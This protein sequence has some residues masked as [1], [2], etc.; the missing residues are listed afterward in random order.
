MDISKKC[1]MA[2][3]ISQDTF[4]GVVLENVTEFDMSLEEAVADAIREFE[5]QGVLLGM[6]VKD[7][8][9]SDDRRSVIHSVVTSIE[10]LKSVAA[11]GT[12]TLEEVQEHLATL[13][14]QCSLSLSHRILANKNNAYD[15][16]IKLLQ[17]CKDNGAILNAC[18]KTLVAL[19]EGNPDI[20]NSEGIQLLLQLLEE[21][22]MRSD[23]LDVSELL[24]QWCM[25][26]CVKHE[27][28]R[29]SLVAAGA[30][31]SMVALLQAQRSNSLVVRAA[32]RA[33]KAFTLDDDIRQ[34]FGNAH[35]H[36]R[37]LAEG[38]QLIGLSLNL[39]NEFDGDS[40][41]TSELLGVVRKL[42]VRAEYCQ[43]VVDHG[44]LKVINDILVSFPDHAEL[45]KQAMSLMKTVAGNDKVKDGAMKA[46]IAPLLVAAMNRHQN[47]RGV[48]EEGCGAVSMLALRCPTHAKQLEEAGA[49][50]AVLQA[51]KIHPK[52]VQI[53]KLGCMA[54][55]N[56]ASRMPENQASLKAQGVEGAIQAALEAHGELVKDVAKAALR[57]LDLPVE[58]VEQW[59]GTGHE[60]SR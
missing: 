50:S 30:M 1:K 3:V 29:Q 20:L 18:L 21:W 45:N 35:E 39:I 13:A 53:Q 16:L 52:V 28:N 33:I 8:V 54:I 26:C 55:R 41:T 17:T 60:I 58:M 43:E 15:V 42:C 27:G 51:M 38:N 49:G 31:G 24:A 44:G 36:A 59:R 9:L 11:G 25:W 6:V 4:D 32:C 57:D 48:C 22:R 46:G 56:L 34:E 10:G 47:V 37:L 5:S 14:T 12:P 19:T 23:A 7:G 2:K 40:E